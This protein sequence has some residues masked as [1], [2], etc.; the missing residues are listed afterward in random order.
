MK[1]IGEQHFTQEINQVLFR[2]YNQFWP[3]QESAARVLAAELLMKSHPTVETIGEIISSLSIQEQPE[4]STL[5][6]KK[7]YNSMQESSTVRSCVTDLLKNTTFGNYYNL[8]QNGSSSSVINELQATYDANVTYG[9]NVEMRPTGMLKRTSFDLSMLGNGENAHLMS[10]SLFVEGFGLTDE[11]QKENP[12]EH[13]AGMQL[14]ILGVHLRPYIFFTGT[15]ELMGLI[16]SGAGNNPTPAVQANFLIIDQSHTVVLQNGI[17][18]DLNLKG[19]LSADISGSVEVSMWNKNAHAVVKNKGSL[20][21]NGFCRVDTSFVESH[22]DFGMGGGSVLDMVVDLD[23]A[24]KPMA[25]CLQ[26]EQPPFI[27]RHNIRKTETIPG[28]QLLIK[29]VKRRS[30]YFPGKSF[31]L[32]RKNSD[33]CRKMLQPKKHKSFW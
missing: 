20:L 27:F 23:F 12:E 16:W 11:E 30:M 22:V 2:V 9:I 18:V 21:V 33:S 28:T 1:D 26:V 31:N 14:S 13:S 24:K 10:M 7:L 3:H 19:A 29:T 17:H 32:F 5:V 8:A 15:G 25:M 6:L 4:I